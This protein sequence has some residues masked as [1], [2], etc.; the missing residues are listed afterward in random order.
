MVFCAAQCS[1]C[2]DIVLAIDQK[3]SIVCSCGEISIT[4]NANSSSTQYRNEKPKAFQL[5]ID[6]PPSSG[7]IKESSG[8]HFELLNG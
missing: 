6:T 1:I 5:E 2:K 3:Q 8:S 4:G 7:I